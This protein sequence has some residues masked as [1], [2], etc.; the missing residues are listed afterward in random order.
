MV[1]LLSEHSYLCSLSLG[2]FG[3][4][5]VGGSEEVASVVSHFRCP[6][7]YRKKKMENLFSFSLFLFTQQFPHFQ[8]D[9]VNYVVM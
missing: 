7:K 8:C 1:V 5:E 2:L 9:T 4:K 3:L 6:S